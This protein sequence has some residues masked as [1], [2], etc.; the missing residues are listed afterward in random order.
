MNLVNRGIPKIRYTNLMSPVISPSQ[1]EAFLAQFAK[2]DKTPLSNE[3]VLRLEWFLKNLAVDA[4]TP[5][6]KEEF[7]L[8]LKENDLMKLANFLSRNVSDFSK[9]LSEFLE[10]D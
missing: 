8:I 2:L 7:L 9:K 4:V 6:N 1:L 5:E 3:H 10:Q